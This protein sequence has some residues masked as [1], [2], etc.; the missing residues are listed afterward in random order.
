MYILVRDCIWVLGIYKLE[1][2]SLDC[3]LVDYALV[4]LCLL[5]LLND[6][7]MDGKMFSNFLTGK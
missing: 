1:L 6:I 3:D 7:A 4:F 2:F 5:Q